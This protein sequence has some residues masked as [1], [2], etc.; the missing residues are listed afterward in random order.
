MFKSFSTIFLAVAALLLL[1]PLSGCRS[2]KKAAEGAAGGSTIVI[3]ENTVPTYADLPTRYNML[4]SSWMAWNDMEMSMKLSIKSP[5]KLNAAGKVYMKRGEWISI[6][7]R[8]LGF[9]VATLWVDADSVVA[10]DKFHK[11]YI[12]EPT[13]TL[14]DGAGVTITDIQDLL[15]GRAF[16]VGKG[17]ARPGNSSL[18]ELAEADNGWYILPKNQP[19]DYSYGFLASSTINGLRGAVVEVNAKTTVQ[20]YYDGIAESRNAGWFARKV[21]VE[22]SGK[23]KIAATIEW[24]LN[25]SKFNTNLNRRCRIPDDYERIP[26]SALSGL[27][28]QL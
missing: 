26:A 17:T 18:F 1:S 14:L 3:G 28:K 13:A 27:L 15:L 7:M 12:S 5:K 11:K 25:N 24:D 2:Q 20:V 16:S 8:M 6:S 22:N 19:A 23:K 9:E 21:S 10:V 4:T